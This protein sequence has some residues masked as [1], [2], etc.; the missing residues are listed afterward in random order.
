MVSSVTLRPE[1]RLL[2][3][4]TF[5]AYLE[6]SK[7]Q[8]KQRGDYARRMTLATIAQV[9]VTRGLAYIFNRLHRS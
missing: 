9:R 8:D 2:D 5:A 1:M 4:E 6:K 7:D 3:L